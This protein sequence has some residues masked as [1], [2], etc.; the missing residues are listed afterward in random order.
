MKPLDQ[1]DPYRL[2][3]GAQM[4]LFLMQPEHLKSAKDEGHKH[5]FC[6][7]DTLARCPIPKVSLDPASE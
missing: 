7:F 4:T 6:I 2:D 3:P 1:G 5:V